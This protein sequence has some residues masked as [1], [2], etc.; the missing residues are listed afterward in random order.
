LQIGQTEHTGHTNKDI[1]ARWR[2]LPR[3]ASG[4]DLEFEP[5]ARV[6]GGGEVLRNGD[7]FGGWR[8]RAAFP[9]S[10][11]KARIRLGFG[12]EGWRTIS[13]HDRAGNN[14]A[15]VGLPGV[16]DLH[17]RVQQ[18]SESAG[19]AQLTI[20][21]GQENRKWSLRVIARDTNGIEHTSSRNLGTPVGKSSVWTYN[22]LDLPLGRVK[23]FLVQVRPVHWIEFRH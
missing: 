23:E 17:A 5:S 19:Q 12:L 15:S 2:D 4:P 9:K 6:N 14:S 10:A 7:K 18:I 3:G 8:M 13:T 1:I 22:F 11:A 16:P 21:L 20:L